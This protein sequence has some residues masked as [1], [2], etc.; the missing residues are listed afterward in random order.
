MCF[1]K[2]GGNVCCIGNQDTFA[3]KYSRFDNFIS[4]YNDAIENG[5]KGIS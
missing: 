2:S 4:E 5:M 3:K 1:V